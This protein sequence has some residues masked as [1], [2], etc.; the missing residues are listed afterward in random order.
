MPVARIK[1]ISRNKRDVGVIARQIIGIAKALGVKNKGPIPLPTRR[2]RIATRKTPAADG[3]H[4]F[5]HWEMR[6]HK[7]LV[8]IDGSEQALRQVMRIPVPDSVQIEMNLS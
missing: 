5:D 2:L 3:S 8:E 4:T 1:I 6:I 7:W